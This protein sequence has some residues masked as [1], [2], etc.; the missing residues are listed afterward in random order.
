DIR[1]AVL[2]IDRNAKVLF[3]G[4]TL[5]R[6]NTTSYKLR[7][8]QAVNL[9]FE[10]VR[11]HFGKLEQIIGEAC[12][13]ARVFENDFQEPDAIL[14]VVDGACEK[15]FRETLYGGEGRF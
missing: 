7:N 11:V 3:G 13:T 4:R 1:Q 9:Q 15:S 12:E 8:A 2:Q 14:R 6:F 5:S 10:A